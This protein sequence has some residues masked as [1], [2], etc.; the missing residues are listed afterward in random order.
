MDVSIDLKGIDRKWEGEFRPGHFAGVVKVV[1]R[2]L[3]IVEPDGLY[4]GQ[5]DFQQFTIIQVMLNELD[6]GVRLVVVPTKRE[7]DGLAM[8]SRNARLTTEARSCA[9]ILYKMLVYSKDN[10]KKKTIND[11]ESYAVDAIKNK[12]LRPEYFKLVS[13]K[14]LSIIDDNHSGNVVAIVAAWAGD[15]RLIDNMII[16]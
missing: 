5:K 13:T 11:I 10:Y 12:G 8:S 6:S 3:D 15:V 2:L 1:K 16:E 14:D 9:D 4:M 7:S